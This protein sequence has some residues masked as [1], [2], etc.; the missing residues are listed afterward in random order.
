MSHRRLVALV[1]MAVAPFDGAAFPAAAQAPD[2]Q[3]P[4]VSS[5][6]AQAPAGT[7][8]LDKAHTSVTMKVSH[9]GLSYYTLRFDGVEG[10]VS[11]DPAHPDAAR[12]QV[13]IDPNS[14]DTG[15]VAFDRQIATEVFDA[16]RYPRITFVST[17]V[18]PGGEGRGVVLGDLS[19][20]G[21][22]KPVRLDVIFNGAGQ[23]PGR[24]TRMGFSASTVIRRS[25][26]GAAKYLPAVGDDVSV[27]VEAEFTK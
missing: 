10:S 11:Y 23:A 21:A 16:A 15:V 14:I 4:E 17:A 2:A 19:F 20:H 25:D 9:L 7:Y 18:R 26:F 22:T 6:P 24:P 1:A 3:P 5:D 27:L 8:T 12:L 13:S